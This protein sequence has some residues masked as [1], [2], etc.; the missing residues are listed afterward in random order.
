VLTF[1]GTTETNDNYNVQVAVDDADRVHAVYFHRMATNIN[2]AITPYDLYHVWCTNASGTAPL[3]LS[4]WNKTKITT[5]PSNTLVAG[6]LISVGSNLLLYARGGLDINGDGQQ[7]IRIDRAEWNGT[8]WDWT[9]VGANGA[10][11]TNASKTFNT[12]RLTYDRQNNVLHVSYRCETFPRL[13]GYSASSQPTNPIP[14][15]WVAPVY[16]GEISTANK[17]GNGGTG[18]LEDGRAVAAV[19]LGANRDGMGSAVTNFTRIRAP[20][21]GG[22]WGPWKVA[23][24]GD[25]RSLGASGGY[26]TSSAFTPDG[27][28]GLFMVTC[29]KLLNHWD[30]QTETWADVFTNMPTTVDIYAIANIGVVKG[31]PCKVYTFNRWDGKLY[32][33]SY[34]INKPAGS[35]IQV[36]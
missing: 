35:L 4:N 14:S 20:G 19:Y 18:V 11:I 26:S 23:F 13:Q 6:S 2:D 21:F 8:S 30:P 22:A 17:E 32:V 1:E 10:A 27:A 3:S 7:D 24:P 12:P 34:F 29:N 31:N 5:I 15:S 36:R 28:G 9:P 33:G 16:Q 25:F